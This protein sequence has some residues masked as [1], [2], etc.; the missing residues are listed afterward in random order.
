[1]KAKSPLSCLAWSLGAL[2]AVAVL[3]FCAHPAVFDEEAEEATT[4]PEETAGAETA[5]AA[6]DT[7]SWDELSKQVLPKVIDSNLDFGTLLRYAR[8]ASCT[9]YMVL[10]TPQIA[11]PELG[12]FTV[13]QGPPSTA[14][15]S[16]S[17]EDA[18]DDGTVAED[19]VKVETVATSDIMMKMAMDRVHKGLKSL[20]TLNVVNLL[21]QSTVK[22]ERKGEGYE[23]TVNP[24]KGPPVPMRLTVSSDF[25]ITS[26]QTRAMDGSDVVT[27]LK[28]VRTGGKWLVT[29]A[30][31]TSGAG[32]HV[33]ST[34]KSVNEY[35]TQDGI[36]LLSKVTIASTSSTGGGVLQ[37]Q[38]E[39]SFRDWQIEKRAEPLTVVIEPTEAP[40]TPAKLPTTQ[41]TP[42]QTPRTVVR[43]VETAEAPRVKILRTE[44][45]STL[46]KDTILSVG[47]AYY[48]IAA[49]GVKAYDASFTVE[50]DGGRV[51]SLKLKWEA[52]GGVSI[53]PDLA[54]DEAK[55][56]VEAVS[57]QIARV[58]SG[59]P[60]SDYSFAADVY[61]TKTTK[62]TVIDATAY[63]SAADP[64]V[65]SE[66]VYVSP[67]LRQVRTTRTMNDGKTSETLYAGEESEGKL[68]VRSA[69]QTVKE[70]G[71]APEKAEYTWTYSK[72]DGV[73]FVKRLEWSGTIGEETGDW[74]IALESVTFEK[75]VARIR[76]DAG[77]AER[78]KLA[79]EVKVPHTD[80]ANKL[81]QQ[82]LEAVE[83]KFYS[84]KSTGV[85]G[86]EATYGMQLG[87][88]GVGTLKVT[89]NLGRPL[90]VTAGLE[91]L[92][93]KPTKEQVEAIKNTAE[94]H[95]RTVLTALLDVGAAAPGPGAYA[96][97]SG[98]EYVIDFVEQAPRGGVDAV[99]AVAYIPE[100]LTEYRE[101]FVAKDGTILELSHHMEPRE[102]K[103][104][105]TSFTWT[106]LYPG[107]EPHK[108]VF[109]LAYVK[110]DGEL[111]VSRFETE[112]SMGG[113]KVPWTGVLRDVTLRKEALAAREAE[114]GDWGPVPSPDELI[115][116]TGQAKVPRTE[117]AKKLAEKVVSALQD[118][119]YS[120]VDLAAV[121]FEA[122]LNVSF[123][124]RPLGI[125]SLKWDVAN[126]L[127]VEIIEQKDTRAAAQN[128]LK[129]IPA[130]MGR[131]I[132]RIFARPPAMEYYADCYAVKDGDQFIVD[133]TELASKSDP[134]VKT[135]LLFVSA[136]LLQSRTALVRKDGTM[137]LR[138]DNREKIEGKE[139]VTTSAVW[140]ITP[141]NEPI[142]LEYKWTYGQQA[143]ATFIKTIRH[144][145][146]MSGRKVTF[147]ATLDNVKLERLSG[148][149]DWTPDETKV[150]VPPKEDTGEPPTAI[151]GFGKLERN[152]ETM[153]VGG[154]VYIDLAASYYN[155]NTQTDVVAF[156]A[157]YALEQN[158]KP[159]GTMNVSWDTRQ[160]LT[161]IVI[162]P[163]PYHVSRTKVTFNPSGAGPG[164]PEAAGK[165]K[166]QVQLFGKTIFSVVA[167][168]TFPF[169]GMVY[170]VK[171]PLGT[172]IDVTEFYGPF[173]PFI[174]LS[175]TFVTDDLCLVNNITSMKNGETRRTKFEGDVREERHYVNKVTHSIT[176]PGEDPQTQEYTFTYSQKEGVMFL[177]TALLGI[178]QGGQRAS[179]KAELQEVHFR[180]KQ[181]TPETGTPDQTTT[182]PEPHV[183]TRVPTVDE[184][185]KLAQE[186]KVPR[187]EEARQ[188][189]SQVLASVQK[190]YHSVFHSTSVSGFEVTASVKKDD[191][192]VGNIKIAWKRGDPENVD[193]KP[194]KKVEDPVATL[195]HGMATEL[196]A[197][198]ALMPFVLGPL[199]SAQA[200]EGHAVQSGGLYIIDLTEAA[201]SDNL[202][203]RILCVP[204]DFS[205]VQ[206]IRSYKD[207][208]VL[209]WIFNG[210]AADGALLISSATQPK[211]G[212]LG[213]DYETTNFT[214]TYTRKAGGVFIK[215]VLVDQPLMGNVMHWT[216]EF[217]DATFQGGGNVPDIPEDIQE[218]REQALKDLEEQTRKALEEAMAAL[219]SWKCA[220]CGYIYD[221]KKGDAEG[222]V[223]PGTPFRDL[224]DDWVCPTC[225]GAKKGFKKLE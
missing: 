84:L 159:L 58:I 162:S 111:F 19:E 52:F 140:V 195:I 46:A 97:K 18:N 48:D 57:Q 63:A 146:D 108:N 27:N 132:V 199:T 82:V 207:G 73:P 215:K 157:T 179:L 212:P 100:D 29:G 167:E 9:V 32:E 76:I 216:I 38:Q 17:W 200:P 70:P 92:P 136:D 51:G 5:G 117:E 210:E 121:G 122:R 74:T 147:A 205:R 189:A 171:Q 96:I 113:R 81:A 90:T 115:K 202:K 154:N 203:A 156:E 41:E 114:D 141:G 175:T 6:I 56:A 89:C 218:A 7:S 109:T 93:G 158:G 83:K 161:E 130:D 153:R 79:R 106:V 33:S 163:F 119:S 34:D 98:N 193:A 77:P 170:G 61:A 3:G 102:G 66:L 71:G 94:L 224:A 40:E 190:K 135:S 68:F 164:G 166:E 105:V 137:T 133:A 80:E 99:V 139:L 116:L 31:T 25:R 180:R 60:L 178:A 183:T 181:E 91:G 204:Q 198:D 85:T 134:D 1:M 124:G 35:V 123:L 206:E 62:Q 87:G 186:T 125:A 129:L 8:K 2:L 20:V 37:T 184:A 55:G 104:V 142:S 222:N 72:K 103:F 131:E 177:G 149:E 172:F 22:A 188:L 16:L 86:F 50:L 4:Q 209:E 143:G 225:G 47:N 12:S 11:M 126:D 13:P 42:T 10:R 15:I 69:T 110:K 168:R 152:A 107:S 145:R 194:E 95:G 14:Q 201:K 43:P 67:D 127:S 36:P 30:E 155:L 221:P 128:L 118:G 176:T 185:R 78:A 88:K 151:P 144:R 45:A 223:D 197:I 196:T 49:V 148:T 150:T 64:N 44:Q 169:A 160:E 211:S 192:D 187:T 26:T 173:N 53:E 220:A 174:R 213:G 39:Y 217:G 208:D 165:M 65:R 28:H 101:I 59:G 24:K 112:E 54:D 219:G 138:V 214:W 21:T 120:F 191:Y 75:E 182:T 23:I